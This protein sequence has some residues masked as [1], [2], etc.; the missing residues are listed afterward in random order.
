MLGIVIVSYKN[1]KGTVDFITKELKKITLPW[2]V[3]VVDNC[4]DSI[5]G[6]KLAEACNGICVQK[7]E[8][9]T[10]T[11]NSVFVLPVKENLG[12]A[13]GNNLGADFL[14]QNFNCEH[15]LFTNDDILIEEPD[16]I[17][18]MI[19]FLNQNED[20]GAIGPRVIGIDSFDQSPHYRII[21]PARQLGWKLLPFVRKKSK[22]DSNDTIYNTPQSS[23]CYWVSGCFFIMK[24]K[25]FIEVKGLDPSTFLY[26]EEVILAERLKSIGKREYFYGETHIVH[27]GGCSTKSIE[28]KQLKRILKE[29]NCI[30][31]RKYLH[32]NP[33]IVW[34]YKLLC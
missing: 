18:K 2:K 1:F 27:Y 10:D 21:T 13:R 20:I 3:V 19:D 24:C 23:Y 26:A 22:K 12:F 15:L 32:C 8:A 9:I 31:Y 4:S 5:L 29:S 7:Q 33:I 14:I 28:N 6:E 25:D 34:L 11:N 30:Y 16:G 17:Q